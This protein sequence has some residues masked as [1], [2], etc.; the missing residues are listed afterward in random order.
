MTTAGDGIQYSNST[1]SIQ[2]DGR[3][4]EENKCS[5]TIAQI[6]NGFLEHFTRRLLVIR[7]QLASRRVLTVNA[8]YIVNRPAH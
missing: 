1:V 2:S 7:S 3:P 5:K 8:D 6:A 4:D